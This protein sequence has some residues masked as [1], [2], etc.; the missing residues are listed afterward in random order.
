MNQNLKQKLYESCKNYLQV[1]LDAINDRLR[2]ISDSMTSE[3]KSSA[4]DKYETG[5]A[6]LHLEKEKQMTQMAMLSVSKKILS[7]ISPESV[8]DSVQSGALVKTSQGTFYIAISAGK[9]KVNGQEFFSITLASPIGKMLFNKK[10]GEAF[11]FRG[12]NYLIEG[13]L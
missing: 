3:T 2:D 4:G 11:D 8:F 7:G 9:M 6:M 1:R 13:V 5:R 12:K 10:K